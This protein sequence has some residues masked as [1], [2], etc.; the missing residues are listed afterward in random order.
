MDSHSWLLRR[1]HSPTTLP[2]PPLI[3]RRTAHRSCILSPFTPA[4]QKEERTPIP[5]KRKEQTGT[6]SQPKGLSLDDLHAGAL[7][8]RTVPIRSRRIRSA[9]Q[10]TTIGAQNCGPPSRFV[11]LQAQTLITPAVRP[12]LLQPA[13]APE[14]DP[15]LS[16]SQR[17][18]N[19]EPLAN[20][21]PGISLFSTTTT[22]GPSRALMDG[23]DY[24]YR[25]T[26]HHL[27]V[28]ERQQ[29]SPH[30]CS[31]SNSNLLN[32]NR[33][34]AELLSHQQQQQQQQQ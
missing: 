32:W 19:V 29:E 5:R 30:T 28:E 13:T 34:E 15:A 3:I 6:V 17:A 26:I 12:Y 14:T 2:S 22:I 1:P 33:R 7:R 23:F 31:K 24:I 8:T 11:G 20:N 25:T 16:T 9:T 18:R 10:L 4:K 21:P 27:S